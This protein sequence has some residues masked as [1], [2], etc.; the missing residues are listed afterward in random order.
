M[1]IERYELIYGE[2]GAAAPL[3]APTPTTEAQDIER[4]AQYLRDRTA[5]A[6]ARPSAPPR[7]ST[8]MPPGYS[9]P[10]I[11]KGFVADVGWRIAFRLLVIFPI[12][13]VL[14]ALA[15]QS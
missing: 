5:A 2:P 4:Y 3:S 11:A 7:V 9:G 15:G 12:I 13:A 6:S 10:D 1:D 8:P 14:H